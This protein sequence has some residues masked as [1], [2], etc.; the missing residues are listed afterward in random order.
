MRMRLR[1]QAHGTR[2]SHQTVKNQKSHRCSCAHD[3]PV[4]DTSLMQ[5]LC[6]RRRRRRARGAVGVK[7]ALQ[8]SGG[9][10]EQDPYHALMLSSGPATSDANALRSMR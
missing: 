9:S 10:E 5:A 3:L 4:C 6:C 2:C 1:L 7:E 8:S